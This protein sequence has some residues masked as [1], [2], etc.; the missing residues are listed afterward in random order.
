MSMPSLRTTA[1]DPRY[2]FMFRYGTPAKTALGTRSNE[3]QYAMEPETY[4][5]VRRM[6][7]PCGTRS[8]VLFELTYRRV[9]RPELSDEGQW[10]DF[11]VEQREVGISQIPRL[12]DIGRKS[13]ERSERK[14]RT[15]AA[16][17]RQRN[18][19]EKSLIG[20]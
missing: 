12:C 18:T 4:Y 5:T 16:W 6:Q 8:A 2:R 7:S 17:H 19:S 10:C 9:W 15:H 13:S 20:R 14:W 3:R 1:G 11:L